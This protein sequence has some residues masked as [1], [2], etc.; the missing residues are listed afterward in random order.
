[1]K[2]EAALIMA[3]CTAAGVA[4]PFAAHGTTNIRWC[5]TAGDYTDSAMWDG[6]V[7]PGKKD[8][9]ADL[10]RTAAGEGTAYIREGMNISHGW[11]NCGRTNDFTIVMSG[12]YV[13][14]VQ[15]E[16][17]SDA[18]LKISR[19]AVV[20]GE[21]IRPTGTLNISGGKFVA[22][23]GCVSVG[24]RGTGV[25][26]MTGG[27]LWARG[28]LSIARLE[29]SAGTMTVSGGAKASAASFRLE[30]PSA[31][32]IVDGGTLAQSKMLSSTPKS[33]NF[34]WGST[35]A[36]VQI[37]AGGAVFSL[38]F[39][40]MATLPIASVPGT[41]G[42]FEKRGASTL[43]F[44]STALN[45][46]AGVTVV[47]EGTLVAECPQ[48]LPGY[49]EPGRVTVKSGANLLLGKGWTDAEK[50]AFRAAV[51]LE[52]GATLGAAFDISEEDVTIPDDLSYTG[53][54]EKY[55]DRMLTLTGRNAF[56]GEQFIY[57]GTLCADIGQG[58]DAAQCV[59]LAGGSLSSV[60]GRIVTTIGS[61]AGQ[62]NFLSSHTPA[63]TARGVPLNVN[64]L[65]GK[66]PASSTDRISATAALPG[67]SLT[68]NDANAD[69]PITFEN[70]IDVSGTTSTSFFRLNVLS[71]VATMDGSIM[72]STYKNTLQTTFK[73]YGAGTLR[74]ANAGFRDRCFRFNVEEGDVV[75]DHPASVAN[76]SDGSAY[77]FYI[78]KLGAGTLY[79]T[80]QA[81]TTEDNFNH[82]AG[83][84]RIVGGKLKVGKNLNLYNGDAVF[85]G[86]A[87]TV[88]GSLVS[89]AV[90]DADVVG[91][92]TNGAHVTANEFNAGSDNNNVHG[93]LE[94]YDGCCVTS[95]YVLAG[96]GD[97]AQFAGKVY[98]TDLTRSVQ[99]GRWKGRDGF[100]YMLGGELGMAGNLHMGRVAGAYGQIW[101][102]GGVIDSAGEISIGLGTGA[103]G[104]VHVVGGVMRHGSGRARVG[105]D[106]DGELVVRGDGLLKTAD[107]LSIADQSATGSGRV[108]LCRGGVIEAAQVRGHGSA[109]GGRY[110][111]FIFD[112]GTLRATADSAAYVGSLTEFAVGTG[113]GAVDTA[114]HDV[115]FA[116]PLTATKLGSDLAHRWSFNGDF[117]DS[118]TGESPV[119]TNGWSFVSCGAGQAVK[120]AGGSRGASHI[121]LGPNKLPVDGSEATIEFWARVDAHRSWQRAFEIGR[122]GNSYMNLTWR[123]DAARTDY[124]A[125]KYNGVQLGISNTLIPYDVGKLPWSHIC[126][127]CKKGGD[128]RWKIRLYR[129]YRDGEDIV[130]RGEYDAP[131]GWSIAKQDQTYTYIGR[132]LQSQDPD[133][134]AS[135]DEFRIW[136]RALTDEEIAANEAAGPDALPATAFEK[137]GLGTLTLTGENSYAQ[138]TVV[139]EGTL[140]L[141]A[142]ASLP[143]STAVTVAG[144]AT[145]DL[146]GNAAV[147]ASVAGEGTLANGKLTLG[148][149]AEISA[150]RIAFKKELL[151]EASAAVVVLEA[152][153]GVN[154]RFA[155]ASLP[156]GY[157]L[158]Y[159]ETQVKLVTGG[160]AIYIR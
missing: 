150:M 149:K 76:A 44:T 125:I 116:Q 69:R 67:L 80:N 133:A 142:G 38:G 33:N 6:G 160:F 128:G 40:A 26:M 77:F 64:L 120:L 54:M 85:D 39:D 151:P 65:G 157:R 2:S 101:Q 72:D 20:N 93:R 94:I 68:L 143:S 119:D 88:A 57:A 155:S 135:Y 108:I 63:F 29:G 91:A 115:T 114:G 78:N 50:A 92:F 15:S 106:G 86:G 112:G 19:G 22:T 156:A 131:E 55:G 70:N 41:A 144:G 48:N 121:S 46:Y 49:G 4:I 129:Q 23:N 139:S 98:G 1:M 107:M 27:E 127:T 123:K 73:K 159:S 34:L 11:I 16:D 147:A 100:Y 13:E 79:A 124:S 90:A 97:I 17:V 158:V 32:L 81:V 148:G 141:A 47:A 7:V 9:C 52:E 136:K 145:L 12:G 25:L 137:R 30:R 66:S 31:T 21:T 58:L 146:G 138:Q 110:A 126:F 24:E 56:G 118:V 96:S 89:G 75:F 130:L 42:T 8:D 132:S 60:S 37:G 28:R 18:A 36:T 109:Q 87:V 82:Q 71:G 95:R 122:D 74:L 51:T 113:G 14:L 53:G 140:A 62:V 45:T 5:G 134:S 59:T 111:E 103:T 152:A 61:G 83:H 35:E 105:A 3:V 102:T 117:V 104:V 84:T 10:S 153:E 43:R 99:V 154:G